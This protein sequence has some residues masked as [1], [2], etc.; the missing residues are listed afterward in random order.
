MAHE[1]AVSGPP[2]PGSVVTFVTVLL[3]IKYD[4][5]VC[6]TSVTQD[7]ILLGSCEVTKLVGI[8]DGRGCG[9]SP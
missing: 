4:S 9:I 1:V 7:N 2:P 5:A 3:S 8:C 6:S